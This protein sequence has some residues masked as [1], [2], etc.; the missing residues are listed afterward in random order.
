MPPKVPKGIGF[1]AGRSSKRKG[2]ALRGLGLLIY[3]GLRNFR[4]RLV[5]R[6]FLVECFLQ[7][8]DRIVETEL[9]GPSAK[10]AVTGNFI[11]F[12][13]LRRCQQAGVEGGRTFVF[14]H[15]F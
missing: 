11:V 7:Q 3:D 2:A 8:G 9:L 5:S 15:D 12:D 10:G 1:G 14:L 13:C 4:Q 6:F